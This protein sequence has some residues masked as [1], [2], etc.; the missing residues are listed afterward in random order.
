MTFKENTQQFLNK[1]SNNSIDSNLIEIIFY[2]C[3]CD[4]LPVIVD[5]SN[6]KN[7]IIN[8]NKSSGPNQDSNHNN[9][10]V[11]LLDE[12]KINEYIEFVS[13]IQE[14][15]NLKNLLNL[16]LNNSSYKLRMSFILN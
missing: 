13:N 14:L 15:N 6:N 12:N 9:S 16:Y 11:L 1:F 7:N 4:C 8:K 2:Y 5:Q 10:P 3:Y